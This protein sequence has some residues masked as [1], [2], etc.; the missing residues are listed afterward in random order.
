M[1]L[2]MQTLRCR[3][4]K[5]YL[6]SSSHMHKD[7]DS[8]ESTLAPLGLGYG[9]FCLAS[10]QLPLH[11]KLSRLP[12]WRVTPFLLVAA[13]AEQGPWGQLPR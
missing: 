4:E 7:E 2:H 1:R 6:M 13:L 9:M 10:V 11:G 3:R 12:L 5:T 8:N